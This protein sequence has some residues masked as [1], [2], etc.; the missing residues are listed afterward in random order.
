[1]P[2][3]ILVTGASGYIGG[4][5]AAALAADGRD[6]R[7]GTRRRPA[8]VD[9]GAGD[10]TWVAY[11][12][13]AEGDAL[14]AAVQGCGTVIHC[15]GHAHVAE[16]PQAVAAA[17]R[18][19]VIGTERLAHAC[20]RHGVERLIFISSAL[21][22]SGSRDRA[23]RIGDESPPHPSTAYAQTKARAETRLRDIGAETGLGWIVLRPP[24]VY[25]PGSPGNFHRLVK[26]VDAGLPLPLGRADAPK[27]FIYVDNLISAVSA[28]ISRP[29]VRNAAFVISDAEVTS[30]AGLIRAI[31]EALGRPARLLPVP[32][33]ACRILGRLIGKQQD[34]ERLFEPLQIDASGFTQRL[35]WRPPVS[36][37]NGVRQTV[38]A[39]QSIRANT[40][41][42]RG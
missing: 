1:M 42:E 21:V 19:N 35:Q 16:T 17:E 15:A 12:D 3:P 13:L 5:C 38:A 29:D 31:G 25:G 24:M 8:T 10:K 27:S 20:A 41:A 6:V 4:R 22:L 33:F 7:W 34:I 18:I 40:V 23:G 36:L 26:A 37:Q 9:F 2:K 28:L 30:T 32:A 11:G 14:D 39:W